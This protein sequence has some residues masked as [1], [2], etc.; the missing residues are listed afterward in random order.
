M[1]A[2]FSAPVF[3]GETIRTEIWREA[4]GRAGFRCSVKERN[5]VV[6]NSGLAEYVV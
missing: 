6:I 5:V 4:P 2:R 3:P 1:D